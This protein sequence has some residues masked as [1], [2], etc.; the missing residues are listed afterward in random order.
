VYIEMENWA[1]IPRRFLV[2]SH[3]R[4]SVCRDFNGH[5]DTL[6]KIL[7]HPELPGY[8][9]TRTMLHHFGPRLALGPRRL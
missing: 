6:Q 2:E 1:E 4:R 7:D 8:H 9:L 3:S 5:W